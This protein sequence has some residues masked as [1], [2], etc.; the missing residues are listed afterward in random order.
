VISGVIM[1]GGTLLFIKIKPGFINI[2]TN[3]VPGLFNDLKPNFHDQTFS[4]ISVYIP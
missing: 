2:L 3:G 4:E 1:E